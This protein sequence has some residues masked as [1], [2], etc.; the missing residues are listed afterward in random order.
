MEAIIAQ[1]ERVDPKIG[2]FTQTYYEE[3]LQ[4][5][6][7]SEERYQKG[8]AIHPLDGIPIAIKE[9]KGVRGKIT[10]A[11]SLVFKDNVADADAI[12]VQRIKAAGGIIHAR[13]NVCEMGAAGITGGRHAPPTRN[14]WNPAYN[15]GGSSGGAAAS[16]ASGMTTLANGSDYCGSI[17]IPASSCGVVGY[18]A[19]RG[20]N[21]V[22]PYFNV[23]WYDHDGALARS[24]SDCALLQNAMSGQHPDDI[25]SLR[26]EVKIP[27]ELPSIKGWKIALSMDLGY[28]EIAP[29]VLNGIQAAA[30]MLRDLGAEVNEVELRWTS[31][32]LDAYRAHAALI[33][34]AWVET[35]L[36]DHRHEMTDYAIE[37]GESAGP[38]K[39]AQVLRSLEIETEMWRKLG[40]ILQS[41]E[42]LICPTLAVPGVSLNHNPV[43]SSFQINGKPTS[44]DYGWMLTYPF[45]MLSPLPVMSVPSGFSKD[46]VPIGLQI[47]GRPYDD[48]SVFAAGAA[49]ESKAGIM[50]GRLP[51]L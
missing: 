41:H 12:P 24:V 35:Y 10:S 48:V 13:T 17:R 3:A 20:R 30:D 31:E 28:K 42:L 34:G 51:T 21:A 49:C 47:V 19:P 36:D 27:P 2:A 40:L 46:G 44:G 9:D 5:A 7:Q 33:F 22:S 6:R 4:E 14:P 45:N 43:D 50:Q 18:K 26:D 16:L 32:T 39:P 38:L 23:D 1:S 15:S 25:F 11:G 37:M 8:D 29:D